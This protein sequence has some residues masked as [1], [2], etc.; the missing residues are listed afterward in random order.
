MNI[1]IDEEYIR[2][3]I[4][5]SGGVYFR[6]ANA[7]E[8][9][10]KFEL[11]CKSINYLCNKS[12][13]S[14]LFKIT[15]LRINHP[16]CICSCNKCEYV[17]VVKD[18]ETRIQFAVGSLC[19]TK[20]KNDKLNKELYYIQKGNKCIECGDPLVMKEND[21]LDVNCKKGNRKCFKCEVPLVKDGRIYTDLFFQGLSKWDNEKKK[22]YIIP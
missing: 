8:I 6:D 11:L 22:W 3:N 21:Y 15:G 9:K 20:F 13:S 2:N 17:Y 16:T 4:Y 19:I 12:L 18:E 14:P 1:I 7:P 5:I 10:N